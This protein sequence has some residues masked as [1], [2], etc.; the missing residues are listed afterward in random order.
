MAVSAR[1]LDP[2]QG[3]PS[4]RLRRPCAGVRRVHELSSLRGVDEG[5]RAARGGAR[6]APGGGLLDVGCGTGKS[7]EAFLRRAATTSSRATARRR[8]WL[9]HAQSAAAARCGCT[10]ARHARGWPGSR[11]VRPRYLPRRLGQLPDRPDDD[12]SARLRRGPPPACPRG[13]YLFDV[14]SAVPYRSWFARATTA[15]RP[16]AARFA[17]RGDAAPGAGRPGHACACTIEVGRSTARPASRHVQRHHP[18]S[19]GAALLG[20]AGLDCVAV[21]GQRVDGGIDGG[22]DELAHTKAIYL[23]RHMTTTPRREGR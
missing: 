19:D 7:F 12:L 18:P 17:W 21:H 13:V 4:R 11:R 22:F 3:R 6:S 10:L 14:N 2:V 9:E 23:A 1:P 5:P 15:S 8:C 20:A 16:R